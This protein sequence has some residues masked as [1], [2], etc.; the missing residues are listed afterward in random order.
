MAD[1]YNK[2]YDKGSKRRKLSV[3]LMKHPLAKTGAFFFSV[4]VSGVLCS[5][6]VTE[7]TSEGKLVWSECYKHC[8]FYC[9]GIYLVVVLI[10][11][12]VVYQAENA[13]SRYLDKEFCKSY[14]LSNCLPEMTSQIRTNV[15]NGKTNGLSDI[16]ELLNALDSWNK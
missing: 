14:I 16:T 3:W 13:M 4:I 2:D 5:A 12:Y 7:I 10:Y 6:F 11:N 1:N 15:K 9:I 8:T